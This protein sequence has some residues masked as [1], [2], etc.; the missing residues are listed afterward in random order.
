MRSK[1]DQL[2]VLRRIRSEGRISDGEYDDLAKGLVTLADAATE[3]DDEVDDAIDEQLLSGETEG[4]TPDHPPEPL[5][6]LPRP[7]F[8][9]DLSPNQLGA[10]LIAAIALLVVSW[11]GML[12]WFVSLLGILVLLTTVLEGWRKV[13][14]I[15]GAAVAVITVIS[16]VFSGGSAPDPPAGQPI[17]ATPPSQDPYPP[18]PGSLGIYMDQVTELWNTV[19]GPP[20]IMRGLTRHNETGDYDTFI[21]RFGEWGRLAGAYDPDN[22]AVYALLVTGQFSGAATDQLYLGLCFV[23]APYSQECIDSYSQ[24]GLDGGTLQ[25]FVDRPHQAEWTLDGHYWNLEIDGNVMTIRVYGE[26]VA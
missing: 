16:L 19:D 20:R 5:N 11:L 8:R 10:L 3:V 13:T 17:A 15:G 23:V 25:D 26:D 7:T 18:I 9:R 21:Y 2:A 4:A 12:P 1:I 14:L 24:V 6:F 22:D